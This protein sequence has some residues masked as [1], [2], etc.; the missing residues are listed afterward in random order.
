MTIL[1]LDLLCQVI[2]KPGLQYGHKVVGL[3]SVILHPCF[4]RCKET[5][6]LYSFASLTLHHLLIDALCHF[7]MQS[8]HHNC[9]L[10]V[11]LLVQFFPEKFVAHEQV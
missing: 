11:N 9:E 2:I 10:G 7:L 6:L 5:Q 1:T 3:T 8:L 4:K